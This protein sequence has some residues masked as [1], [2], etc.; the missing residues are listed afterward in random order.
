MN[1]PQLYISTYHYVRDLPNT[2]FPQIKGML[3]DDFREQVK[4]LPDLFEM[5]TVNSALEFLKGTYHPRRDLCLMTFDDGLREHYADVTPI[6]AENDIQ[7]VFFLIGSA[8]E[9]RVVAPVHMNHFLTAGLG[10][11]RYRALFLE[12]IRAGGFGEEIDGQVDL[13]VSKHTYPLDTP[14]VAQ[15]KYLFNFVLPPAFRDRAVKELFVKW[16]GDEKKFAAE[17][18]LSWAEAR[19]MQKAGMSIGGHTLRHRPLATLDDEEL[20]RDLNKAWDLMQANLYPQDCWPFSYPYGKA[21]SFNGN[22][23]SHLQRLGFDFALCTEKGMNLP[24]ADLFTIRRLDCKEITAAGSPMQQRT[25]YVQE[26]V[27]AGRQD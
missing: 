13:A 8:L 9:E 26:P 7:G 19:E 15:F 5:A 27:R 2:Q 21:D 23:I 20:A 10:F 25:N 22:V 16:I 11:D 6:L 4:A 17:L 24:G 3:L 14:E 12:R 18:Y 1:Q